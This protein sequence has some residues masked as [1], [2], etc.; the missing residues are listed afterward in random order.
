ML[1]LILWNNIH[2]K[3][4]KGV[5]NVFEFINHICFQNIP[6]Y[7]MFSF[8][9]FKWIK[10]YVSKVINFEDS[11]AFI[12]T[13]V[14]RRKGSN[15]QIM[16]ER[17]SKLTYP[18]LQHCLRMLYKTFLSIS[19]GQSDRKPVSSE[20]HKTILAKVQKGYK[21]L[22]KKI[23]SAFHVK[24]NTYLHIISF[25][26]TKFYEILLSGFSTVALTNCFS[27][28]FNFGQISKFNKW[29]L[30]MS[31]PVSLAVISFIKKVT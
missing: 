4:L 7:R 8:D 22:F 17:V 21:L 10:M 13:C 6:K 14:F 2:W 9:G 1:F 24:K 5:L 23:K 20:M 26:T 15:S 30:M 27:S 31:G 28:F 29:D 11:N 25:I 12:F 3:V 16:K 18:T 19:D